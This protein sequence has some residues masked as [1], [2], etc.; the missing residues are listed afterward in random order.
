MLQ[1]PLRSICGWRNKQKGA[2]IDYSP[3]EQEGAFMLE[4]VNRARVIG[5]WQFKD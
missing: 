1:K 3:Y 4:V 5:Q 2:R